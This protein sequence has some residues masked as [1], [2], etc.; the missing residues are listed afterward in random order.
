M[1]DTK[2]IK[3]N[4]KLAALASSAAA[5]SLG[6]A[7]HAESEKAQFVVIKGSMTLT[8]V[9]K[10]NSTDPGLMLGEIAEVTARAVR[11]NT[12]KVKR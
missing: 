7:V 11:L 9:A 6:A 12:M 5:L 3:N 1:K 8:P 2:T 4:T 10:K